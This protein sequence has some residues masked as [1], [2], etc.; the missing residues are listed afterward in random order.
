MGELIPSLADCTLF[1]NGIL[2]F[3]CKN[4]KHKVLDSLLR[5][6]QASCKVMLESCSQ[7]KDNT[8][9]E[10]QKLNSPDCVAYFGLVDLDWTEFLGWK[11]GTFRLGTNDRLITLLVSVNTGSRK[12]KMVCVC[13]FFFISKVVSSVSQS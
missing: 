9:S 13:C 8:T 10:R 12:I 3:F 6:H 5:C 4:L 11:M 7:N 1:K 2:L